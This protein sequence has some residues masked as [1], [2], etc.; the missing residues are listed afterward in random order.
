MCLLLVSNLTSN[1]TNKFERKISGKG[2]MRAGRRFTLFIPNGDINDIIKI[3]ESL[4]CSGVLID[5]VTEK[6]KH[7]IKKDRLIEALLA[8]LATSLVQPVT[9]LIVKGI[10][11]REVRRAGKEYMNKIFYFRFIL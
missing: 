10:R 4:E 9:S 1:A 8:R 3:I 6:V 7:K 5:R 11:G 2:P